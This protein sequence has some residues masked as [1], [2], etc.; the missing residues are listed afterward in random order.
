ML[1]LRVVSA[2]VLYAFLLSSVAF[3]QSAVYQAPKEAID[4]IKDEGMKR[5]Q[6]MQTLSYLTDVIGPRLTGSPNLK[7]A[8]EWAIVQQ[9]MND[10]MRL[11]RRYHWH[12]A[13]VRDFTADPHTAIIGESRGEIR[14]LVEG[15]DHTGVSPE[16][17]REIALQK[18]TEVDALIAESP[19][20]FSRIARAGRILRAVRSGTTIVPPADWTSELNQTT[21]PSY[22]A[23]WISM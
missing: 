7:A 12:S 8:G 20:F 1:R 5:S 6:V 18:I 2:F 10:G 11:A 4:K 22:C 19:A 21:T 13:A 17:W 14:N 23:P 16:R 3:A 15:F 9:G